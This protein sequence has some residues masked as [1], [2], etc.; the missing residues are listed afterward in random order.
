MEDPVVVI[1][2][3][4]FS[5][6]LLSICV[7]RVHVQNAH[8]RALTTALATNRQQAV[9]ELGIDPEAINAF[10]VVKYS[11]VKDIQIGKGILE[12]AVCLSEFGDE[13]LV[14]LLPECDHV[15]HPHCI[16]KWLASHATCPV[17]RTNLLQPLE[18]NDYV[19]VDGGLLSNDIAIRIDD[20]DVDRRS[21]ANL[22]S[23]EQSSNKNPSQEMSKFHRSHSTGDWLVRRDEEFDKYALRLPEDVKKEIQRHKVKQDED[24]GVVLNYRY[25]EEC[26]TMADQMGRLGRSDRFS[27]SDRFLGTTVEK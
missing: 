20:E 11:D 1:V 13:D 6:G 3:V 18:S 4:I 2:F 7:H 19:H 12:C 23:S 8:S 21:T 15:F 5:I 9:T 24:N 14:R 16:D 26:S 27:K 22:F 25:G 10:P 17:C